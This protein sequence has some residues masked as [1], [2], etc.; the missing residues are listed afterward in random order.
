MDR[1]Q[2]KEVVLDV[3]NR[4]N[5]TLPVDKQI[6]TSEDTV[7]Y[8]PESTLTS[9]TLVSLVVELELAVDEAGMGAISLT[10]DRA[11]SSRRS[12]FRNVGTLVDYVCEVA[13]K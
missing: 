7:L 11:M 2:V 9:M 13:A 3:I 12:P 8:G 10:D 5:E 1:E 6:G 4:L